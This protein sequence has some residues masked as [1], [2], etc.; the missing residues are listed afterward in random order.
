MEFL[1]DQEAMT[2]WLL[3]YGSISLFF[4]LAL[5]IVAMPIPDETLMVLAGVLIRKGDLYII[6]TLAAAYLGSMT[7]MT[8][9]Y[10]I[11]RTVG[12]K[13]LHRYGSR[14]GL[15]EERLSKAHNWF[16][17]YGKWSLT[18]GYFVPG[19]RHLTGIAAGASELS[20]PHFAL[21]A[22]TGAAIW[23]TFFLSVG[24]FLGNYWSDI[25]TIIENAGD[26]AIFG[27]IIGAILLFILWRR[28]HRT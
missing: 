1:P 21:F 3:H 2:Y 10:V 24:Y 9:S 19:I 11:G 4:L 26:F 27:A 16:E 6:P 18:F 17:S 14:F 28:Y 13:F 8:L 7:G 5:G 20:Y 22:Y 12:S 15:T 25:I 23:A